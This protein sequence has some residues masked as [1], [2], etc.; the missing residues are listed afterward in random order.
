LRGWITEAFI[1]DYNQISKFLPS[2]TSNPHAGKPVQAISGHHH[3]VKPPSRL[4]LTGLN[5]SDFVENNELHW[6]PKK[7]TDYFFKFTLQCL[8]NLI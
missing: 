1:G 2:L 6:R 7:A 5:G 4:P 3:R 8:F